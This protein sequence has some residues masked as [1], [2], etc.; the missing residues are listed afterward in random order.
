MVELYLEW[1][2]KQGSVEKTL[3]GSQRWADRGG[4]EVINQQDRRQ[5]N[6]EGLRTNFQEIG[7]KNKIFFKNLTK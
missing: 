4:E 1:W 3:L 2:V 5:G 7:R 6:E